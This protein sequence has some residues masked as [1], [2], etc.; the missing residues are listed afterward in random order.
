MVL[1]ACA[2]DTNDSLNN[3]EAANNENIN[4][5][6]IEETVEENDTNDDGILVEK[7]QEIFMEWGKPVEVLSTYP[8]SDEL[9]M[10]FQLT[11]VDYSWADE[12]IGIGGHREGFRYLLLEVEVENTDEIELEGR[13]IYRPGNYYIYDDSGVE[14][15]KSIYTDVDSVENIYRNPRIRPGGKASGIIVFQFTDPNEAERA[16]RIIYENSGNEYIIDLN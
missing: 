3:D 15:K 12:P 11:H 2:N 6:N 13:A 5:V 1:T 14:V 16:S 7:G 9:W 4:A 10:H 8:L